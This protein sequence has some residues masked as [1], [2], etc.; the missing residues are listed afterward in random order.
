[1]VALVI[2]SI[3]GGAVHSGPRL[4]H[5][6]PRHPRLVDPW[7]PRLVIR[8]HPRLVKKIR[9]HPRLVKK[10]RGHPRLERAEVT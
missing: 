2:C 6:D 8:G 4:G 7:H 5:P 1:L 3:A 10:I 9:E